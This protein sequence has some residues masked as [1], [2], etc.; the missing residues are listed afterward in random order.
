M[1]SFFESFEKGIISHPRIEW[2]CPPKLVMCHNWHVAAG[3]ESREAE[4]QKREMEVLEA[5]FLRPSAIP[6]SPSISLAIEGEYYDDSHT[7]IIPLTPI[8][9]EAVADLPSDLSSPLNTLL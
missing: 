9:E 3:E 8:E 1:R 4:A 2:K 7:P 6:H 5:V